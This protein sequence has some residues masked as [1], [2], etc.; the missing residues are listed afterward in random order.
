MKYDTHNQIQINS[1]G[2]SHKCDIITNYNNLVKLFGEP[3]K[4]SSDGKTDAEWVI[5]LENGDIFT[6]YNWKNGK[7]YGN[8]DISSIN[9]WTI[10]GY[11]NTSL[12]VIEK[13]INDS[14]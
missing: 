6:I 8:S 2:T 1:D 13:L 12:T 10:G 3:L 7:N 11:K 5:K 9:E 4:G 14:N